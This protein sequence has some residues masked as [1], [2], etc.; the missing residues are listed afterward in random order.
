M[1]EIYGRVIAHFRTFKAR[2]FPKGTVEFIPLK[3][4]SNNGI[5]H[6]PAPVIAYVRD[7]GKMYASEGG[8]AQDESEGVEL[9]VSPADTGAV[10]YLVTPRLYDPSTGYAI[11]L[12]SF[13]LTVR[14]GETVDLAGAVVRNG[15]ADV[16]LV[17]NSDGTWSLD[18]PA[19]VNITHAGGGVWAVTGA[20]VEMLANGVWKIGEA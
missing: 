12:N 16:K 8:Y 6:A 20:P 17:S 3:W 7:D 18:T 19:G 10:E 1:T 15:R 13:T 5:I 11:P 14:A 9:L 2:V 4:A